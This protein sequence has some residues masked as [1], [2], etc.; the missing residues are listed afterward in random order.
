M[1]KYHNFII[2]RYVNYNHIKIIIKVYLF[3]YILEIFKA[4]GTYEVSKLRMDCMY[5]M[6]F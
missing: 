2:Q 6:E 3:L 1:D 5:N 4:Y